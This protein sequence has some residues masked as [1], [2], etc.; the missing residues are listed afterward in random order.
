MVHLWAMSAPMCM[1]FRCA[2][3]RIEKALG[4]FTELITTRTRTTSV[5]F[6]DPPS[7]SKKVGLRD[8]KLCLQAGPSARSYFFSGRA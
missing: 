1:Q 5:A 7:G 8:L 3:L 2:P 6:W 4:I